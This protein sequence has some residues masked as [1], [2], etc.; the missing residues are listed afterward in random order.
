LD[1]AEVRCDDGLVTDQQWPAGAAIQRARG[2]LSI[3]AA[4][5][6]AGISEARWRHI[7]L[8][9]QIASGGHKLPVNPRPENV[10]AVARAVDLDPAE[11]FA[12]MGRDDFPPLLSIPVPEVRPDIVV[13]IE[14]GSDLT[15]D[16]RQGATETARAAAEAYVRAVREQGRRAG[17]TAGDDR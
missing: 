14:A 1:F 17:L 8:G 13:T 9:Y 15:D 12:L 16:E 3:R 7:E 10:V 11:L 6:R 2:N 4:A 5:K